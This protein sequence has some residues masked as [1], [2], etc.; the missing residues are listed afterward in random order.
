MQWLTVAS[1]VLPWTKGE[2]SVPSPTVP[3]AGQSF[4]LLLSSTLWDVQALALVSRL[5]LWLQMSWQ[6]AWEETTPLLNQSQP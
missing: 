2:Q 3:G 1:Q 5:A 4:S 6:L